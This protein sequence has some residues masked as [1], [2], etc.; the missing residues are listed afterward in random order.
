MHRIRGTELLDGVFVKREDGDI[1]CRS[2]N[3]FRKDPTVLQ[4]PSYALTNPVQLIRKRQLLE[5]LPLSK[6]ALHDLM[7]R[8]QRF[9]RPTYL[10]GG[11]IPYWVEAEVDGYLAKCMQAKPGTSMLQSAGHA[12]DQS[13]TPPMPAETT[14]N[15]SSVGLGAGHN[16]PPLSR[17]A[18]AADDHIWFSAESSAFSS[19]APIPAPTLPAYFSSSSRW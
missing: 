2:N 19:T 18:C 6:S 12:P 11:R 4:R 1:G 15:P 7:K 16:T 8:D 5:K 17:G 14:Q 9:P 3:R 13:L 10:N